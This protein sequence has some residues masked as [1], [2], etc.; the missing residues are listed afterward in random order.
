MNIDWAHLLGPDV[1]LL[2]IVIRGTVMYWALFVLLRWLRRPTGQLGIAD[3]LLITL[4]AD[5]SQNAMGGSYESISSGLGLVLT[6][7]FWDQFIDRLGYRWPWFSKLTDPRPVDLVVQGSLR[8]K[9]L[10]KHHISEEELM[11]HLRQHG[12]DDLARVH[13]CCLEGD[14]H[15]SV[16]TRD[17]A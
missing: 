10:E 14:G 5:A 8:R 13:R 11:S 6:I 9:A 12:L 7:I 1:S 17:R 16:V 3:V 2:E 15:I 4:L